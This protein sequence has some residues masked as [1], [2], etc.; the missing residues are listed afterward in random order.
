[1]KFR[2]LSSNR[3][4]ESKRLWTYPSVCAAMLGTA[5][6]NPSF[7]F[8]RS[9][10]LVP[11]LSWSLRTVPH[12]G[13]LNQELSISKPILLPYICVLAVASWPTTRRC[14]HH[15]TSLRSSANHN[16]ELFSALVFVA[17]ILRYTASSPRRFAKFHL[18]SELTRSK[19]WMPEKALAWH[20]Q[21]TG[22]PTFYASQV[23]PPYAG[24][25]TLTGQHLI[26]DVCAARR[27]W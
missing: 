7:R 4:D 1:M 5:R 23:L 24:N 22:F 21:H 19:P 17:R 27:H 14:A 9:F 13:Y 16:N 6:E 10:K 26:D 11:P 25:T 3:G 12:A 20:A 8:L 18:T 2:K 15:H